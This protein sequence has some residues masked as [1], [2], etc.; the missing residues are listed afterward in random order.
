MLSR[1]WRRL[2][3]RRSESTQ[4]TPAATSADAAPRVNGDAQAIIADAPV[5]VAGPGEEPLS[6][7][8]PDGAPP[9]PEPAA[10][11][12]VATEA[13]LHRSLNWRC[14]VLL[15]GASREAKASDGPELVEGLR[16]ATEHAIRQ[17]P[18]AAQR[19]LAV[20]ADPESSLR[21]ITELFEGDPMLAQSLLRQA[22]SA[23]YRRDGTPITSLAASVQ[24][25]GTKGVQGVLTTSL[26]QQTLCRP[27]SG[28]DAQV[29]RV[30]SHMQRTAPIA[31]AIAPVFGL[32][33]ETAYSLALL[34]DVGKLVVFDHVSRLRHEHR[35]DVRLPESFLNLVQLHLH[36]PIGGLA[37]LNWNLGGEAAHAVAEHHRRPLPT[38]HD[39]ATECLFVAEAVELAHANFTKLEWESIWKN[40]GITADVA[41]VQ[42]RLARLEG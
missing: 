3:G 38:W 15:E 22:N 32:D 9:A 4:A 33:A 35:R 6:T 21:E 34:H 13:T 37:V 26:I 1:F 25:I 29:Q 2:S 24:R 20:A 19:A 14:R 30:W 18:A 28:F 23:Y 11:P 8:A 27:G 31:R 12:G 40:G 7:H 36:E 41:Q 39:A 10:T 42:D 17:P 16:V 5:T